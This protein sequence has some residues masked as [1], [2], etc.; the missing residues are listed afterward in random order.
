[1]VLFE[2]GLE[3]QSLVTLG[4]FPEHTFSYISVHS[5]QSVKTLIYEKLSSAAP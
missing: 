4:L 1:M 2:V 5:G 3:S